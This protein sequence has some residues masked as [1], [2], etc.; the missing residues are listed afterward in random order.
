[1]AA[2]ELNDSNFKEGISSIDK[3]ILV[4][5]WSIGCPPCRAQGPIIETMAK[6]Y[7]D[8]VSFAKLDID[9][10]QAFLKDYDI[11]SIPTLILF[12]KGQVVEILV[13]LQDE[14]RLTGVL[15]KY[16]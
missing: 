5:F 8:K 11:M 14:S 16:L 1:M 15:S 10:N 7:S 12:D 6:K 13:G 3:P 9:K 2:I 4:D